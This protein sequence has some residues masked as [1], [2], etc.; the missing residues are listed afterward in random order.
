MQ[1]YG[2]LYIVSFITIN[3]LRWIGHINGMVSKRMM[4]QVFVNELQGNRQRGRPRYRWR[5]CVYGDVTNCRL[6]TEVE[7]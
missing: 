4:Y 5:D 6:G 2:D 3:K 7:N 1:L